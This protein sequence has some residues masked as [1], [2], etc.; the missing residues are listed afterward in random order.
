MNFSKLTSYLKLKALHDEMV[1]NFHSDQLSFGADEIFCL[2]T[3]PSLR[4]TELSALAGKTVIYLNNAYSIAPEHQPK[5]PIYVVSDYL[6]FREIRSS[7]LRAMP[8]P[9][10]CSTD[11]IGQESLPTHLYGP[12]CRF[13][14]PRHRWINDKAGARPKIIHF[15]FSDRLDLGLFMG[16]SVVFSAI[17]IAYHLGAKRI[18][19]VGIDMDYSSPAGAYYLGSIKDNWPIFNYATHARQH[20]IIVRDALAARG[21]ELINATVGGAIDVLPRQTL[22]FATGS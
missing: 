15:G 12:P 8:G 2:G 11:R 18:V 6:R 4:E 16:F 13:F 3:G 21:V 1:F 22:T 17:Q 9:I 7:L 14:M 19:L 20:F 5:Q 10:Y